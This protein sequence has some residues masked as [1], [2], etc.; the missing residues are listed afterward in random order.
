[1]RPEFDACENW[2]LRGLFW[3]SKD[4]FENTPD[5]R[6]CLEPDAQELDVIRNHA[7][8]KY[9]KLHDEMWSGPD[10]KMRAFGGRPD[11]LAFSVYRSHFTDK[12]LRLLKMTRASLVYLSLA[13]HAEERNRERARPKKGL[14]LPMPIDTYDD[15]WKR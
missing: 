13:V 1:M 2:P 14:V 11:A 7:E 5:F 6:E 15:D 10:D 12:A 4:L 9:L 3:L 8:H